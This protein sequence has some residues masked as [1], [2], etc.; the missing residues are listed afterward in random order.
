MI[1][2]NTTFHFRQI[3]KARFMSQ[4]FALIS[5]RWSMFLAGFEPTAFRLGGG[6]S[7]LLSDRNI[8][9]ELVRISNPSLESATHL[10]FTEQIYYINRNVKCQF[11]TENF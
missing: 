8:S 10:W 4:H 1:M 2:S 6:R 9:V 11:I 7:I 3:K 5:T